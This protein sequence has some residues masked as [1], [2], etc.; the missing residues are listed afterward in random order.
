MTSAFAAAIQHEHETSTLAPDIELSAWA[1]EEVAQAVALG[2]CPA[3]STSLPLDLSKPASRWDCCDLSARLI[4]FQQ[5]CD[6][7][8]FVQTVLYCYGEKNG[9]EKTKSVFS[10]IDSM[11]AIDAM[12][13]LGVAQGRGGGIFDPRGQLT[14]Q[15][16]ATFLARVYKAY[17]GKFSEPLGAQIFTDQ[18]EIADWAKDSIA[19]LSSVGI[20]KGY[21]NGRFAPNDP[22]SNEQCIVTLLRLY[23]NLPVSRK[24]NN[25]EPLFTYDQYISMLDTHWL[26]KAQQVD[27]LVATFVQQIDPTPNSI[28]VK[29]AYY[30][31]VYQSGGIRAIED[32]GVCDTGWG[33][34]SGD[35]FSVEPKDPHFSEDGE[36]FYCTITLTS[37]VLDPSHPDSSQ[38][39]GHGHEAGTYQVTIDVE[40]LEAQAVKVQ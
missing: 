40:T 4:A 11:G 5:N 17:G 39:G 31:F 38:S 1:Q 30:K 37:P 3:D 35:L 20:L 27:G 10:D 7:S 36:T 28:P 22:F 15:E 32:F 6:Y 2:I 21:E 23:E 14:R 19:A 29:L 12:Y 16:A 34:L 13:Y 9:P 25:V 33:R 8:D 26:D 24:N 18:E